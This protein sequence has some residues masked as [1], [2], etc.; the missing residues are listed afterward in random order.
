MILFRQKIYSDLEKI[1]DKLQAGKIFDYDV[2]SKI[3]ADCVSV[4]ANLHDTVVYIPDDFDYFQY[5]LQSFIRKNVPG[6]F[7]QVAKEKEVTV[8]KLHGTVNIARYVGLIRY[9]IE[10]EEFCSI[11]DPEYDRGE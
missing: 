7:I 5:D 3:P 9:I 6:I 8:L 10:N 4:S 2:Q 11:I 1:E